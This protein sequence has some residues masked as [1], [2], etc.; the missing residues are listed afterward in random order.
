MTATK[1]KM[2]K[3]A[4]HGTTL[5]HAKEILHLGFQM[6]EGNEHWLGDGTY[7][8]VKGIG[9]TPERAS[10]LWAEYRAYKRGNP[11]CAVLKASIEADDEEVLVTSQHT[12]EL[13]LLII[14]SAC[15]PRNWLLRGN[16][17]G[18]LMVS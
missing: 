15:V 13:G 17:Q 3:E 2:K 9:Y 18:M 16:G 8:F 6:S 1:R 4:Y 5:Q 10:E 11:F 7:F 12:R 14:S